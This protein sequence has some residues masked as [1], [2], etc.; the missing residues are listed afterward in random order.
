MPSEVRRD[1]LI[2]S[3]E[4]LDLRGPHGMVEE[5]AVDEDHGR[6]RAICRVEHVDIA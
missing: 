5:E 6:S 4:M 3:G 2:F 1:Y